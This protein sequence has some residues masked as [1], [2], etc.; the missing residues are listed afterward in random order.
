MLS[1]PQAVVDTGLSMSGPLCEQQQEYI[2]ASIPSSS[3]HCH[4]QLLEND[5]RP[6]HNGSQTGIWQSIK[7][8][9]SYEHMTIA[10]SL[11]GAV[12]GGAAA[13]PLGLSLGTPCK[14]LSA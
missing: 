6:S 4:G 8:R 10:A 14:S 12:A 9:G 1:G 11:V 7:Q 5:G 2:V 3:A 13:G